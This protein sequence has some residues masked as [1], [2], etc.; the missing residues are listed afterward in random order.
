MFKIF[1]GTDPTFFFLK[2]FGEVDHRRGQGQQPSALN[3]EHLSTVYIADEVDMSSAF[4]DLL[5]RCPKLCELDILCSG[6]I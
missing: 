2:F 6:V 1:L 5:R 3:V 4:I